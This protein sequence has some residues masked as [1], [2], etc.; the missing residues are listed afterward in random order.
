M[1]QMFI[2]GEWADAASGESYEVINPANGTIVDTVPLG[3]EEDAQR[4]VS[5]AQDAFG[6]WAAPV[7][8]SIV[9]DRFDAPAAA[10]ALKEQG[11]DC[12]FY[13]SFRGLK[14][15]LEAAEKID[16]RPHILLPGALVQKDILALPVGFQDRIY[17]SYPTLPSDQTPA[18]I[19]EF[20]DLLK[21][22]QLEAK[23]LTSQITAFVAAKILVEGGLRLVSGGTEN[24]LML[25]DLRQ[26]NITGQEAEDI[27][28]QAGITTNKN[29]IPFDPQPPRV[30]SG[31]RLGTPAVTSRGFRQAEMKIVGEAILD[32]LFKA[33]DKAKIKE[34]RQTMAELCAR[35]PVPG[36]G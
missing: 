20:Q 11:V 28:H 9:P 21:Q 29:L 34:I 35:F 3:T 19:A 6:G 8:F 15:L 16:W 25:V 36:L 26:A 23:H 22:H 33:K 4:A 1:G 12:L 30:T 31:I 17:L 32:V 10:Q 24:H 18:G 7:G 13:L 14:P 2:G 5:A 27:L